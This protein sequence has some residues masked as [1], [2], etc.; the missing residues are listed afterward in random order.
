MGGLA[1]GRRPGF[2]L[3]VSGSLCEN[4]Y[5]F[6]YEIWHTFRP[7]GIQIFWVK[8]WSDRV[9][10]CKYY[11]QFQ[12]KKIYN[13]QKFCSEG[14]KL[15]KNFKNPDF[16]TSFEASDN[17]LCTCSQHCHCMLV[18]LCLGQNAT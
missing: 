7:Y 17:L 1:G 6:I 2:T 15:S 16:G 5:T 4:Y 13:G 11:F 8:N 18:E 14:K 10:S 12:K 3:F 9:I